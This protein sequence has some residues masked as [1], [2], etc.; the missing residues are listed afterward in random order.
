MYP[1][2][3]FLVLNAVGNFVKKGKCS[4]FILH[5]N[6]EKT[7]S[8]VSVLIVAYPLFRTR[9]LTWRLESRFQQIV[10]LK[11]A[12]V[13]LRPRKNIALQ[14]QMQKRFCKC[15]KKYL[16]HLFHSNRNIGTVKKASIFPSPAGM[17][18]SPWAGIMKSFINY[19]SSGRVW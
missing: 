1:F 15:T 19:S 16:G 4:W 3:N 5:K 13:N 18:N 8:S 12:C 9:I 17:P 2:S 6:H 14:F 7:P 10:G 11:M